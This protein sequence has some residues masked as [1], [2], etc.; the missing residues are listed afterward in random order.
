MFHYFIETLNSKLQKVKCIFSSTNRKGF[1]FF[2]LP[3]DWA[4]EPRTVFRYMDVNTPV[5]I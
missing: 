4:S 5:V 2:Q 3:R 1:F